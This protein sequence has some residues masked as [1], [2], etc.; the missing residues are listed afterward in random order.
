MDPSGA[1]TGG[2]DGRADSPPLPR[3]H[4]LLYL[5]V[6]FAVATL[7]LSLYLSHR[8]IQRYVRS[9]AANQAWAERLHRCST[10]GQL[11]AGIN[12]PGN[13]VFQSHEVAEEEAKMLAALRLFDERVEAFAAELRANA[14]AAEAAVVI[15]D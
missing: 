2:T 1:A 9:G 11:A 4:R 12:A 5:L 15:D 14:D 3:W 10:L 6:A 7:L 8:Y 13:D